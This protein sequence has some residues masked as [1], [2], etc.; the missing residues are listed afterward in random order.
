[1]KRALGIYSTL[2]S[3]EIKSK[4]YTDV[5]E[6]LSIGIVTLD[7]DRRIVDTNTMASNL[8]SHAGCMINN[9]HSFQFSKAGDQELFEASF[10]KIISE[11]GSD[12][13]SPNIEVF[14]IAQNSGQNLGFLVRHIASTPWYEGRERPAVVVYICDPSLQRDTRENFVAKLFGLMMSEASLAIQ[15]TD[16]LT[17]SEAAKKL[18]ITENSARTISKRIFEKTGTRRQSELIRLILNSVAVLA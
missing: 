17:L 8:L 6:Q 18:S 10:E 11:N 5:I 12:K 14:R 1:M 3:T 9:E 7:L 4:T 15:L 16:G 2:K 13:L